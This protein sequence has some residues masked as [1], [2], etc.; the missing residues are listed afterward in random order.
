VGGKEK[1]FTLNYDGTK[2]KK[3]IEV[4]LKPC[5]ITCRDAA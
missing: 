1:K 3:T 4:S 5:S 2:A